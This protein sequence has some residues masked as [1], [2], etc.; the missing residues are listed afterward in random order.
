[1]RWA[2]FIGCL[3]GCSQSETPEVQSSAPSCEVAVG[4]EGQV[5]EFN[6]AETDAILAAIDYSG[7]EE[8]IDPDAMPGLTRSLVAYMVNQNG[9]E[10]RLKKSELEKTYMGRAVL[11]AIKAG[12]DTGEPA[13][14]NLLRRGL[15]RY[16]LCD[17]GYPMTLDAFR[18]EIY[19]YK[20]LPPY[21]VDSVPKGETRWVRLD[22]DRLLFVAET[23]VDDEVRETEM[24]IGKNRNDGAL[25]FL[26][27]DG[28]GNLSDRTDVLRDDKDQV[29][30]APYGCMSCH[31]DW[32]TLRFD[33]LQPNPKE[34]GPPQAE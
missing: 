29:V 3:L 8:D 32:N 22:S 17:R 4:G 1:M 16:Y 34:Q 20:A 6:A 33:L 12:R 23:V 10:L 9:P 13:D 31:I 7:L 30:D 19:D 24:L 18:A 25:D 21:P 28:A 27:Y 5:A 11:A 26:V 15:H 2:F 14:F